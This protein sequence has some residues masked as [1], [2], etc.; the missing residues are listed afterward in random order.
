MLYFSHIF[1][2]IDFMRSYLY[3]ICGPESHIN[4]THNRVYCIQAHFSMSPGTE[5]TCIANPNL[6]FVV[7]QNLI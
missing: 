2:Q 4:M 6:L 5:D 1:T 3:F 7:I